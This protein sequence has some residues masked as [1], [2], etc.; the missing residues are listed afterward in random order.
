V[1]EGMISTWGAGHR[2]GAAT[3]L[4]FGLANNWTSVD[5]GQFALGLYASASL[6][7]AC[8]ASWGIT[9]DTDATANRRQRRGNAQMASSIQSS[10][11]TDA[12]EAS[13]TRPPPRARAL[14]SVRPR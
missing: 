2:V 7:S 1:A 8:S 9:L 3:L 5:P 12:L 4:S 6:P 11:T 13:E 10:A 14:P